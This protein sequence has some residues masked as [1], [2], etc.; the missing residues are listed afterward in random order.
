[1][2]AKFFL[3]VWLL[4]VSWSFA[5]AE[6]AERKVALVIGNA[7]YQNVPSLSNPSADA[8]DIASALGRLGFDVSLG[9]D[10]DDAEMRRSLRD[11]SRATETA[12]LSLIY[13]AGHGIE[14]DK[15]NFLIPVNAELHKEQD[16]D[17]EA[18]SL[19][20][21][22]SSLASS[23]GVK[24]VLVDACRDNPFADKLNAQRGSRSIGQGLVR[25][26]PIGGVLPGGI[27]IGYA[28]REGRVAFDGEGRNSPYAQ[29]LLEQ[30]EEPG[31]EVSKLFRRVRDRVFELTAGDQEPFTYGS[32]PGAD[33]FL[34]SA[35]ANHIVLAHEDTVLIEEF[36]AAEQ[37]DAL[38]VWN[39]FLKRFGDRV[40]HPLVRV[41]LRRQAILLAQAQELEREQDRRVWLVPQSGRKTMPLELNL[42]E[43]KLV[44]K[45]L[46]YLGFDTGGID[47]NFGPKTR[48]AIFSA[49]IAA[50]LPPG[51]QVDLL[52]LRALPDVTLVDG[53]RS[54]TA[55]TYQPDEL[56]E[57]LEP[58]LRRA[59]LGLEGFEVKFDYF[60]GHL[61]LAVLARGFGSWNYKNALSGRVGGHLATI[62]NER[63]NEFLLNLFKNDERF[64]SL[65]GSGYLHG[66]AFGLVQ[67]E[68][69]P[70]PGG[71][72]GWVTGEPF[73]Y[74]KWARGRPNHGHF[75]HEFGSFFSESGN[76]N[77][78]SSWN[79]TAGE[80]PPF[81]VEIE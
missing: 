63:E 14:I 73:S 67:R 78:M 32:L 25:V 23:D 59:L 58:R 36:A 3:S 5:A 52:L 55:R 75:N 34:S 54:E 7:A 15:T 45:S 26:D 77:R 57:Y 4:L 62:S 66:P 47:G 27:L 9:L 61:Y 11:F 53:L 70:E 60:E 33:I 1:M 8:T 46:G 20:T 10:L 13:F 43:R 18:V 69:A 22:M 12:D 39:D 42:D 79:D 44:Q 31:L 64:V 24:I 71:G 56:P 41:A 30:I 50:G 2:I 21:I 48:D 68:G 76:V 74:R 38:E 80:R 28:A 19:D 40:E 35:T 37:V 6:K 17:F 81:L 65:D 16:A 51:T 29:A 72:W 49:R